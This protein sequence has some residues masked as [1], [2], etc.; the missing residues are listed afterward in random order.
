[1]IGLLFKIGGDSSPFRAEVEKTKNAAKSGGNVVGKLFG[2]QFKSAVMSFLGAGAVIASIRNAIGTAIKIKD[3]AFKLGVDAEAFQELEKAALALGM[4]VEELRDASPSVGKEFVDLMGVIRQKGGIISDEDVQ[5]LQNLSDALDDF[6]V[7]A[8]P[9]ITTAVKAIGALW[10]GGARGFE[11]AISAMRLVP[12]SVFS[13]DPVGEFKA[14]FGAL[15]SAVTDPIEVPLTG[16]PSPRRQAA[17]RFRTALDANRRLTA[18]RAA[19]LT[20]GFSGAGAGML[21]GA[22]MIGGVMGELVEAMK[23]TA[24]ETEKVR[25]TMEKRL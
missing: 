16:G 2:E 5:V 18:A 21:G 11:T 22:P 6:V 13:K 15:K 10:A 25:Q 3:G 9:A 24:K 8:A 23:A 20:E 14:N 12:G 17:E 7:Q 4:T 1:M 19:S